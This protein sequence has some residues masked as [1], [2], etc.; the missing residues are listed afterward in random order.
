[1]TSIPLLQII[2]YLATVFVPAGTTQFT[3]FVGNEAQM[4]WV[5]QA[6]GAWRA[7][8]PNSDATPQLVKRLQVSLWSV[9]GLQVSETVQAN[10]QTNITKT[11][12]SQFI[13]IDT[14]ADQKK[15]VSVNG[16][17]VTI[18]TNASTIT[19][20]QDKDGLFAKPVVVKY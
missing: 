1:M 18:S 14:G 19:F 4:T 9:N 20:S 8:E 5:R 12:L 7:M 2:F 13:K 16:R 17:P 11:D 15:Q 3:V 10:M 6:D